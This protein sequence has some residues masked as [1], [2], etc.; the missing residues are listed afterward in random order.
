VAALVAEEP[1]SPGFA[2]VR[3]YP[4]RV[5]RGTRPGPNCGCEIGVSLAPTVR[6]PFSHTVR[7]F[8]CAGVSAA[9]VALAHVKTVLI[10]PLV[11]LVPM[12][13]PVGD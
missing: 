5:L 10:E 7:R 2:R 9:A 6:A 3:K 12:N 8:C 1:V 11:Y 13:W 4:P